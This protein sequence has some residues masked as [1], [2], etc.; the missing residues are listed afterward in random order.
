MKNTTIT[1][2]F[3]EP[4][5]PINIGA[6]C[7]A[8]M[9]F[10]FSDLRLVNPCRGYQSENARKMALSAR[11]I[12]ES[13]RLFPDLASALEDCHSAFGTTRRFGKYRKQFFFPD[14]AAQTIAAMPDTETCA[15]VFGR[16]DNGLTT[17]ELDL[18][19]H[20]LTIPTDNAFGS[21]NLSH[22]L[23][24][25]L[26]ELST[27]LREKPL[28][29]SSRR[30]ATIGQT[31]QMFTHMK[32]T[33]LDIDYL[34]PQNPDHLLRT[35]RRIFGRAGLSERDVSIIRGLLSRIDWTE[36]ERRRNTP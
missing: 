32:Q 22:A 33:L 34:D 26:Y 35:F 2:V 13:A 10:G 3:V 15:L 8:M 27:A 23:A 17:S 18:C 31:E 11:P 14:K 20:F 16:E 25:C 12:L 36:A 1:V 6:A 9:N 4:Q 28:K 19:T 21:M 29:I 5:G 30:S 24:V 7:R